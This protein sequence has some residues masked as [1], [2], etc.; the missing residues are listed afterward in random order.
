MA[1]Q[2]GGRPGHARWRLSWNDRNVRAVVYQAL[3]LAAVAA[4]IW[5]FVDNTLANLRRLGLASG[6]GF[7]DRE[8]AF[9]IGEALID[10]TPADT[11]AR[12]LLV[13][14]VNTLYVSAIG[15]VIATVLGTAIG[16]ARLSQ[17]WLVRKMSSIYIEVVRN[18]PLLLQLFFWYMIF[19]EMLPTFREALQPV[20]GLY[21]SN[22][23]LRFPVPAAAPGWT[24]L[25]AGALAG[26]VAAFLT[27]NWARRRQEA[28]GQQFPKLWAGIGMI[29]GLGGLGWLV[30]G[31]PTTFD[32]PKLSRF[33]FTGGAEISP[34]FIAL[35]LGLVIY[36]S[37]FVAEI[38][39]GGILA[40]SQGQTEAAYALGLRRGVVLRLVILPQALR[41]I[42][43]PMTSQ[44]LNL[45]KNSSLAVAIG[46][47]DLVHLANTTINQTGQAIEGIAIIMAVY[48]T[49]SLSISLFMNWYNRRVA[50]VE[51]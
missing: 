44:Y 2:Y 27:A 6:F 18:T 34:E 14:I 16:I 4:G 8:A 35:L 21:L 50:L 46:Y 9:P 1:V 42:I 40:I 49:I 33:S 32:W 12:A 25:S 20:T 5:Y 29:V 28:T 47:P 23:G 38:V 17:N 13:G 39:R 48:L 43:P 30:G 41:V 7:M 24:L 3:A 15:I 10:Y 51:R 11:Y 45:T 36:T 31:A 26:T 37:A 19:L 22:S